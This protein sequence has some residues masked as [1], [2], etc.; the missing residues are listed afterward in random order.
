M[1]PGNSEI[2]GFI[3]FGRLIQALSMSWSGDSNRF[4][5]FVLQHVSAGHQPIFGLAVACV[6]WVQPLLR[7]ALRRA[8]LR[9]HAGPRGL[10]AGYEIQPKQS[11][12]ELGYRD[13]NNPA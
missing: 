7:E 1:K 8:G 11:S 3:D 2:V 12:D 6:D 5:A 4:P 13:T 9:E 10:G